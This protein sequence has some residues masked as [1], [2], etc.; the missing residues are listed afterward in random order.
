MIHVA[1]LV[2]TGFEFKKR[3]AYPILKGIVVA[4]ENEDVILEVCSFFARR[5]PL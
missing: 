3:R 1:E 4:A 2:Q 5:L